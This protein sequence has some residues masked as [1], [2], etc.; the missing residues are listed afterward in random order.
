MHTAWIQHVH[1]ISVPHNIESAM[2][3][4]EE[5]EPTTLHL[6][7]STRCSG[8]WQ[9]EWQAIT[10]ETLRR[11]AMSARQRCLDCIH[12]NGGHTCFWVCSGVMTSFLTLS[13]GGGGGGGGH[14]TRNIL[15]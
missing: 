7:A 14:L 1:L 8:L 4:G 13:N 2:C 15:S 12:A 10:K 9:Q 5:R 6:L 3:W 11:L